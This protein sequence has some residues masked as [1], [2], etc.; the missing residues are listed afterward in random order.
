MSVSI[1]IQRTSQPDK[2]F[3][4][5]DAV[6]AALEA[7][8]QTLKQ[9]QYVPDGSGGHTQ[10]VTYNY[11]NVIE[12]VIRFLVEGLIATALENFAD[13]TSTLGT[14]KAQALASSQAA[15]TEKNNLLQAMRTA[16]SS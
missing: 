11:Q 14:I 8:R 6:V 5:P 12:M 15:A 1:V 10:Q 7:Y 13:P 16:R 9:V 2:V 3:D 4:I